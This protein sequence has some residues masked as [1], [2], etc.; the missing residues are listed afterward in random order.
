MIHTMTTPIFLGKP[1]E[2]RPLRV[3]MDGKSLH[4]GAAASETPPGTLRGRQPWLEL[5][6]EHSSLHARLVD[7][8]R[9]ERGEEHLILVGIH[10]EPRHLRAT[11]SDTLMDLKQ[12]LDARQTLKAASL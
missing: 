1:T 4:T 6:H 9:A 11:R 8:Q 10:R 2:T 7:L 5:Y 3:C 12:Q